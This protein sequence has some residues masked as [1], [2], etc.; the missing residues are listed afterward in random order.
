[1]GLVPRS[2]GALARRK[3]AAMARALVATGFNRF[4]G[5]EQANHPF[6]HLLHCGHL[7]IIKFFPWGLLF[8]VL[9]IQQKS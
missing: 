3:P 7:Y 6:R 8:M 4:V 1:M 5:G 9:K 2:S